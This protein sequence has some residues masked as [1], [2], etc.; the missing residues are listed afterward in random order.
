ML[1]SFQTVVLWKA[2]PVPDRPA[3]DRW[4][5]S[6]AS[7]SHQRG[8][9][10][11][12]GWEKI[13]Q[14]CELSRWMKRRRMNVDML[15]EN[16]I[17]HYW[18]ALVS[19]GAKPRGERAT[20]NLM[21]QHLRQA[22]IIAVKSSAMKPSPAESVI[23]AYRQYLLSERSLGDWKPWMATLLS[24]GGFYPTGSRVKS[25]SH[26]NSRRQILTSMCSKLPPGRWGGRACQHMTTATAKSV[27]VFIDERASGKRS[28]SGCSLGG[29][30]AFIR[31]ASVFRAQPR[32]SAS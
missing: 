8:Y 3:G 13:R 20:F 23:Q 16:L 22:K 26:K 9:K 7:R 31:V 2:G 19:N 17:G 25:L 30:V 32:W 18:S 6:L 4:P 24:F 21:L 27:A 1:P 28:G 10:Y 5:G 29:G 15:D 12:V 14:L 11:E